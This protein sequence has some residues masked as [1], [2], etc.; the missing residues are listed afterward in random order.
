MNLGG[1]E[2]ILVLDD[3]SATRHAMHHVLTAAGYE[4]VEA[5][6]TQ[7]ALG[8]SETQDF[9]L[10]V[11]DMMLSGRSSVEVCEALRSSSRHADVAVL[12]VSAT[13]EGQ[14]HRAAID[15]GGDDFLTKPLHRGELLLRV[16]SLLKLRSMQRAL[17]SSNALLTEQRDRLLKLQRQKDELSQIIVHDLKNPLAAIASN[18][19]FLSSSQDLT[20]D[21]R[22]CA[23][24][25]SRASDNMLRM[26]HNILDISRGEDA[27]LALHRERTDVAGLLERT[28]ALMSRRAQDKRVAV[29]VLGPS[30]GICFDCDPDLIR[31][32]LENLLD[33]ALRYTPSR[34]T[35][36]LGVGLGAK[37]ELMLSVA[38]GGPGIPEAERERVFEKYAQLDR[39]DD[40]AQQRFGRGIGLTFVKMAVEAHGGQIWVEDRAVRGACFQI[41]LPPAA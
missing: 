41:R 1:P 35:V 17:A 39:P 33:N 36:Q 28:R 22:D 25:I 30:E 2:R 24:S 26:V 3:D 14:A 23:A 13:G 12:F 9:S 40:H 21:L 5:A 31:R 6:T 15:A 7:M 38:D 19:S 29:E 8:I 11:L 37:G 27:G 4:V 16:R 34:S 10:V 18:A 32:V 20:G